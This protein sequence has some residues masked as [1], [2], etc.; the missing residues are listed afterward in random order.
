MPTRDTGKLVITLPEGLSDNDKRVVTSKL[1]ALDLGNRNILI[2]I[3]CPYPAILSNAIGIVTNIELNLSNNLIATYEA[4]NL[5]KANPLV[6]RTHILELIPIGIL[7]PGNWSSFNITYFQLRKIF[8][9]NK[10]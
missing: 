1:L 7:E 8:S 10:L 9:L 4:L 3:P 6:V 2:Y 5:D